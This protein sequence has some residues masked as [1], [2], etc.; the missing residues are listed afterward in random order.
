MLCSSLL[1]NVKGYKQKYN[2]MVTFCEEF[3]SSEKQKP[4]EIAILHSQKLRKCHL[5]LDLC[6]FVCY[7]CVF[8]CFLK[9][10]F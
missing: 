7:D 4:G 3:K 5:H 1:D 2:I 10:V 8:C 6:L 9:F